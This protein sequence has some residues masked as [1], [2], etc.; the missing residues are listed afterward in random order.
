MYNE[1]I[2]SKIKK[3]MAMFILLFFGLTL[4]LS[5]CFFV[6]H[7]DH[8]CMDDKCMVCVQLYHCE[9]LVKNIAVALAFL[10]LGKGIVY[11]ISH[12]LY[13]LVSF[14]NANKYTL[15]GKKIRLNI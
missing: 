3:N 10:T 7:S 15:I 9:Q 12:F 14:K 11:L 1:K 13:F 5:A 8:N 6:A 4:I 2:C